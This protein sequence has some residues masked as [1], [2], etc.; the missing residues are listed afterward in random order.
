MSDGSIYVHQPGVRNAHEGA[1]KF[2]THH[3]PHDVD[4]KLAVSQERQDE[5]A[6]AVH[7]TKVRFERYLEMQRFPRR[8]AG[9]V[10]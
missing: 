9:L 4:G 7:K 5:Y 8:E 6:T 3:L 10:Q 2:Y 1:I